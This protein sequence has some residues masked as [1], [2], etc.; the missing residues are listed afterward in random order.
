MPNRF[1]FG[2]SYS[3]LVFTEDEWLHDLSLM[4]QAGM[5][6]VR[7]GD[8]HGSWDL[9]EPRPGDYQL[10]KLNRFYMMAAEYGIEIIISTGASGPPLWLAREHP[11]ITLLSSCGTSYPLG[12]SYHWTCIHAPA[13]REA[14]TSYIHTLLNFTKQHPNHFG[15]Q[16]SNELGFPFLPPRGEN[17]LGLYCYCDI[18]QAHFR[19]WVREKY[20]DL[21]ALTEAWAWGTTYYVY[22]DWSDVFPPES[23]PEAWASVTRW[24]DWRLFWQAAFADFA[25]WQHERIKAQDPDHPTSVNVFNFKSYDRFGVFTGLDQWQ[26]AET[27]DHIGYDLYPGSGNKLTT[28]PEHISMFLDHGRSVAKVTGRDYWLHEVE[29]GPIGGWVMGPD[30]STNAADIQRYC[31]EALGHDVKLMLFMP[32]RE[33]HYQ[34]LHWGALVHLDGEP[35]PRLRVAARLGTFLNKYGPEIMAASVKTP[36]VAV[37][38][39]KKN[40]IFFRGVDQDEDLF[41]AQRGAYCAVWELG[42]DVDFVSPAQI[43]QGAVGYQEI[44]LPMMGLIGRETAQSLAEFVRRGGL[45]VG[46]ARC[47]T[48]DERGWFYTHAPGGPLADAFGLARVEP[49]LLASNEIIFDGKVYQGYWNRDVVTIKPET[50]VMATFSDGQPAVT[51]HRYGAG[52]GLYIATQADT[53]HVKHAPSLLQDVLKSVH[54]QLGLAPRLQVLE[55]PNPKRAIDPHVLDVEDYSFLLLTAPHSASNDLSLVL[56]DDRRAKRVQMIY[57]AAEP[58][59]WSQGDGQISLIVYTQPEKEVMI[60]KIDWH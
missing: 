1:Y 3:P 18:C 45:L 41:T 24:L 56:N 49:D 14:L 26:L 28:R 47:A 12:A 30:R 60:I 19:Q 22:N 59:D 6:L 37:L 44:L 35:T 9:I 29:S 32:W 20:R 21:D 34:P 25:G 27:V 48:L 16:V 8:V 58:L 15:W 57:P 42:F 36:R 5:N 46:F 17:Q 54:Q 11:E 40:A 4:H 43:N 55:P 23:L 50:Q 13:Y 33:W 7:L 39:S 51:L 2:A 31:V 10:E 52:Y 38:D 53:G